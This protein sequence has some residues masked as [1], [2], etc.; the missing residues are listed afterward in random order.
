L[1]QVLEVSQTLPAFAAIGDPGVR[2]L[3]LGAVAGLSQMLHLAGAITIL[4][5][6]NII[7]IILNIS[8]LTF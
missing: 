7:F 1:N 8:F 3:V 5:L 4:F 6:L 2:G